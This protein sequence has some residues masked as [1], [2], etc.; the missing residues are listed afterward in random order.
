MPRGI[1]IKTK[2]HI[3]LAGLR[4]GSNRKGIKFTD[5]HKKNIGLNS[6]SKKPEN[7]IKNSLRMIGNKNLLG[8]KFKRTQET[9]NRLSESHRGE[10]AYNYKGGQIINT[11]IRASFKYRQWVSDVFTR[12]DFT[13]QECNERGIYLEA[14]HIKSFSEIINEYNIKT[15]EEALECAE[16]WDINNGRTLCKECHKLTDNY[17][18]KLLLRRTKTDNTSGKE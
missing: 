18:I 5:E 10:K 1:Y 17:G 9:I 7:R 2:E 3:K 4:S 6:A 12:D 16:L 8:K 13:C 11:Q 14:H 15:L